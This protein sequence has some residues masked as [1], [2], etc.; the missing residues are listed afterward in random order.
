MTASVPDRP[1]HTGSPTTTDP[2]ADDPPGPGWLEVVGGVAVF[3]LLAY[4]RLPLVG[5]LGL[6][7]VL[8]GLV[9]A[10]WSGVA[11][12]V[13]FLVARLIRVRRS[14]AFHVRGA[15]WRW[16]AM[17]VAGG[18]LAF[19]LAR[20]LTALYIVVIGTPDDVQAV[21]TDTGRA[22]PVPLVLSLVF[23]AVLTPLREE[24]L[25]RGVVTTALLRYGRGGAVVGSAVIFAAVH[26]ANLAAATALI[27]GLIN[28][29]LLRRSRSIWPGV[30]AH[31]MNNVLAVGIGV[32]L[33]TGS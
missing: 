16:I 12:M 28:A 32:L 13:G 25:F 26:G 8:D 20:L 10:A 14:A 3:L 29:E 2:S 4:V 17:G 18:L 1:G 31:A 19:V 27:V 15:S 7:P 33:G 24:L 11:G 5:R 23:L 21:Y 22:G 6:A 30:T 9:V